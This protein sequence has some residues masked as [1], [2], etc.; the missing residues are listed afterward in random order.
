MATAFGWR[1]DM[2]KQVIGLWLPSRQAVESNRAL[3]WLA[4]LLSRPS[5]WQLQRRTVA[6]RLSL[7]AVVGAAA[8]YAGVHVLWCAAARVHAYRGSLR[9]RIV[10]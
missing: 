8:A 10:N 2:V 4:P 1:Y 7:F 5:L 3:C 6:T 9:N